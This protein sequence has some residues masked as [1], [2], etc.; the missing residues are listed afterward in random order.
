MVILTACGDNNA[1]DF[2]QGGYINLAEEG[3]QT[4][5][6][7]AKHLFDKSGIPI[8]EIE[9]VGKQNHPAWTGLYALEYL[10][11]GE[12][13]KFW[14]C[15]NWLKEN[16]VRQNGYD[17]W[18]YEFDNTY[19]D[20]NIK[21]PWYSGFGQALGIEALVAAYKESKDQVYLDT[22]VKAAEVLFVPISEKGLLFESGEDIWFEEIPVPVENPSHILNGHMRALLAIK[23]LAEVTGNNE[24]NDW[25]E[26]GSETLKKWLPNYDTGYWLRYDLNP[27]KD[28]LL[29]RFNNPYGYQLP[30]LA[31]DKISLK[32]PVSNEEVTLDVGSDVD[33][34]SSLRIA[35]NDWGTIEDLDG[36]TV[37]RIKEIIPTIDHEKLD[38]DFDSPS[39]Y[40]YLKL[41][42]EWK[43]NLRNDWFELTVHYKDEK[44]GNIT[45]QQRSIAP[46]KTFQ[47]MRDGDLLLT[48]SG[49]WREWKIPVRVSDLGYWVGS[50]YGDKHLEY[51]TKLTK[52]DSGLQ[53]W[54]DKM[55]SYRTLSIDFLDKNLKIEKIN[56]NKLPIQTPMLDYFSLDENGVL[57]Q[58]QAS[59]DNKFTEKGWDHQGS[60]GPPVYSPYIIAE[61]AFYGSNYFRVFTGENRDEKIKNY[62]GVDPKKIK[63][64][65][66]YQ[67]IMD[68]GKEISQTALVWEFDFKNVYNDVVSDAP[69][70]SAFGQN[71]IIKAL[72]AGIENSQEITQFDF[73][74]ALSKAINAYNLPLEKGGLTKWVNHQ[75]PFFEE[76]PNGTHVLNAHLVSTA[77]FIKTKDFVKSNT[78]EDLFNK[79]SNTIKDTLWKFDNGY[80]SKYDQNPKKELLFQIDWLSGEKSIAIDEIFIENPQTNTASHI[81]VGGKRD[82]DSYPRIAGT[83][84]KASERIDGK[85]VRTF[86]NGY[87][88]RNEAV[89]G[90][91]QHNVFFL[92]VLPEQNYEEYFNLPTHRIVIKYKDLVPGEFNVKIQS[93]NE[94]NFLSF[95]PL[96]NAI[97][98]AT[99]DGKW[100]EAVFWLRSQDLGWY[101]GSDYQKFHIDQLKELANQTNDW[102]Y[103]QYAE[104]WDY[105]LNSYINKEDVIIENNLDNTTDIAP[106]AKVIE[107]SPTYPNFG[108]QNA[109]DNDPNDDYVA[110]KENSL[111]QSFTLEFEKERT[112]EGIELIWESDENYGVTYKI[113]G[114]SKDGV[115][116][117]KTVDKGN[118][119]LQ[120]VYFEKP[121]SLEKIKISVSKTNGQQRI[122]MRQIKVL[123]KEK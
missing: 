85:T 78:P 75:M 94:G 114:E 49:E 68:N 91:H 42:S 48:G 104:K 122:L 97:I 28:E 10:E 80:W 3:T 101:M 39:T 43:N 27:K 111:P 93:I 72:L 92:G 31:I 22:A 81:D 61:Q 70:Q 40:F 96:N 71:Y 65:P 90:G 82:F 56:Q 6:D 50:S 1:S 76:V 20:I 8:L 79:G 36:K 116:T 60:P 38:G 45:V 23:Y 113:E 7:Q 100:K 121:N 21:A 13:D 118:G 30:N 52:Y 119:K 55:K 86:S 69:W 11:K 54:K 63:S 106:L 112:V 34:N 110:F 35:G 12:M 107:A 15:V 108:M 67:W 9:G 89:Q 117:L 18:L 73:H 41:P 5:V 17:V 103:K 46:G 16:L 77:N 37:R 32:D 109:L 47:N 99:G 83:D 95:K 4:D 29:F 2:N 24:Y 64:A 25:F 123:S 66:A 98:K 19:N 26:K 84:W 88:L 102:F 120:K 62:Y 58:H 53:Q 74:S 57:R 33:A 59:K 51:L 105:Y 115:R 14:A 44:K 87:N